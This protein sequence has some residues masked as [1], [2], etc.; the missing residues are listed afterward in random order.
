MDFGEWKWAIK[1]FLGMQRLLLASC[2][3]KTAMTSSSAGWFF[4]YYYQRSLH[5]LSV[6]ST[7]SFGYANQSLLI[8]I[9]VDRQSRAAGNS[10]ICQIT[11]NA[12][13]LRQVKSPTSA[14]AY[15]STH[16]QSP[17]GQLADTEVN[18]SMVN[19]TTA[20]QLAK[21]SN[22]LGA[23]VYFNC[24]MTKLDVETRQ[25]CRLLLLWW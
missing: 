15:W 23:I 1:L 19:S 9:Q 25:L 13:H 12:T 7:G 11:N 10:Q 4:D 20:S 3:P 21:P 14:F 6:A 17:T 2:E 16:W 18:S 8:L 24:F 22:N 5:A